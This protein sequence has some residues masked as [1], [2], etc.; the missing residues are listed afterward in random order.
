MRAGEAIR[1]LV[2][3]ILPPA[4]MVLCGWAYHSFGFADSEI[5]DWLTLI[6]PTLIGATIVASM[7]SPRAPKIVIVIAYVAA[8]LGV[9][10]FTGIWVSCSYGDCL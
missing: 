1:L 8:M 2:A 4:A 3:L 7:A 9:V 10:V 5:V 6:L